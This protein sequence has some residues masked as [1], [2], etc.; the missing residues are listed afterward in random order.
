MIK[1][2]CALIVHSK[3]ILITQRG[4]DSD[5]PF[6]W[7]FPGGKVNPGETIRGC[8]I[9]EIREELDIEVEILEK[10]VA[11]E[12]DYGFKKI[13]LIPFLCSTANHGL[14]LNEHND[15]KWIELTGLENIDFSEADKKLI[16]QKKNGEMLKKYF[17]E[18][19]YNPR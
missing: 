19:M 1:V 6:Q 15:F 9:R 4:E 12:Y 14:K 5:H 2:T 13:K 16:Q 10:M 11:V 17:R 3:K 18:N 7:E 8:I